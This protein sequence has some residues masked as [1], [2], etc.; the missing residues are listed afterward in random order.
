MVKTVNNNLS[1]HLG[2][3][4]S[5]SDAILSLRLKRLGVK[6]TVN[7]K[8]ERPGVN[9][10]LTALTTNAE[11]VRALAHIVAGTFGPKGLDCM[12]VGEDGEIIITN[13]GATILKTIDTTH[14][15]ARIFINAIQ[16][17]EEKVGDGTTT[18]S[19]LAEAL[20]TEGVNQVLKGVPVIKVID[21]IKLGVDNALRIL[22][23]A[24]IPIERVDSPLLEQIALISARGRHELAD[25]VIKAA[26]T[27]GNEYLSKPGFRLADQIVAYEG[28][29]TELIYGTIINREP[30]NKGMPRRVDDC[31]I[32][33]ID[34]ALEPIKVDFQALGTEAGFNR[35]LHNQELLRESINQLARMGLK[36]VFSDRGI[37]DQ[38]ESYL[39]DLGII[40]VQGVPRH[41]W[42]RLAVFTGARPI[43]RDSLLK[44]AAEMEVLFGKAAAVIVDED[45]RNIKVLGYPDQKMVTLL[46]GAYTKEITEEKERIVKDAAGAVQAAWC[47]GV[48]PGG[49]SVELGIA[50][51]LNEK[52][53]LDLNRYGYACVIE[54]L[55]RPIAQICS[56]A[57]FDT[58]EKLTQVLIA[59]EKTGSLGIGVNCETGKVEDLFQSGVCD[60]YLVK[61]HALQSAGEVVEGILRI[62][63]IVKM[64]D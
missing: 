60:P 11:A 6:M 51:L 27:L 23:E 44:T 15:V 42:E 63:T 52:M 3:G 4:L 2:M 64:K 9:Q 31:K 32:L 61:Y 48:V 59:Q 47:G 40:G 54:A 39:A 25:L 22:A 45:C 5:E 21:G 20:I 1:P 28:G 33:I 55:K 14:P 36:A 50:R 57:G 12:L 24:K 43:K 53:P 29:P 8:L 17:Q 16:L 13:D 18:V 37:S 46:V 62:S 19:L 56:N 35:Q 49:G 38:V 10:P 30:L 34:D 41:E 26:R 58:M 7:Q